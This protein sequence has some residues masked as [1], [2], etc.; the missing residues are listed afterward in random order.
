MPGISGF[1]PGRLSGVV[2][3]PEPLRGWLGG[4]HLHHTLERRAESPASAFPRKCER[5]LNPLSLPVWL[6]RGQ[7]LGNPLN[8]K[9]QVLGGMGKRELA[10]RIIPME[11]FHLFCF[12]GTC[13]P[14]RPGLPVIPPRRL[15][16]GDAACTCRGHCVVEE[17]APAGFSGRGQLGCESQRGP[18]RPFGGVSRDPALG[19]AGV[20]PTVL[21]KEQKHVKTRDLAARIPRLCNSEATIPQEEA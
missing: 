6:E 9:L 16:L 18:K 19:G 12:L 15:H 3:K 7:P 4:I 13:T 17:R 11:E 10:K 2:E 14:G 20:S 8:S 5:R 1:G 21:F